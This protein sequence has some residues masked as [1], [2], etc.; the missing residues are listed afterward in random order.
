[1]A[2]KKSTAYD[3]KESELK[4]TH[5][6]VTTY[7]ELAQWLGNELDTAGEAIGPIESQIRYWWTLYEQGRT[8]G[9]NAPWPDAADL[10]SPM[11]SELVDALHARIMQT[12]FTEPVWT[13]EGW[14]P[15]VQKAPFVEEF[16]QRAVE[17]ER[18]QSM[19]DQVFLRSLVEPAGILEVS[20][21]TELRR[22][23]VRKRVKWAVDQMT[24][25]PML[26]AKQQPLPETTEDGAFVDAAP[27]DPHSMEVEYDE[28]QPIRKGPAY[29][30]VPYLDFRTLP[31]HA[32]DRTQIWGYAKRFWRRVPEL[33][34]CAKDGIYD[35]EAVEDLGT[36]N[37]RDNRADEA[38]YQPLTV[39]SQDG[40]TAQKELWSVQFLAD[41]DGKGERWYRATLHKDKRLLLRLHKDDRVTRYFKFVPFPKP[42]STDGYSVV[43]NKLLTIIEEDT[44]VRNMR[45]D[46][47]A[48]AIAS[49]IKKLQNALW[50]EYEQPFGPR[51]VIQVRDMRELE[52]MP[53][54]DVPQ[55]I[56][57]WKQDIRADADRQLGLNDTSLAQESKGDNTLGEVRLR[58]GYA[59]IRMDLVIKR[60]KEPL[61]E[62]WQARHNIYLRQLRSQAEGPMMPQ[63]MLIGL[64]ARGVDTTGIVDGR[65]TVDMLEGQFWAKPKGSVESADLNAQMGYFNQGMVALANLSKVNQ[66]IGMLL[67]S[68]PAAKAI[69]EQ[70]ARVFR[71]QD[72]QAFLGSEA[73]SMITMQQQQQQMMADPRM[74]LMLA[75]AQGAGG[76]G[77][78]PGGPPGGGPG[79]MPSPEA[80]GA[81][82][83]PMP[84]G[85]VQ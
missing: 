40:P 28:L 11:A 12:V 60:M 73:Q 65:I 52:Q 9:S 85:M 8:R 24:G 69:L 3:L 33:E 4:G 5:D 75:M 44:A 56:N 67:S 15:S 58:A 59:E 26:D 70:W 79:G 22:E 64:E 78:P 25:S 51:S 83:G 42:G 81:P 80:G 38:P 21:A 10:T 71:W 32:K 47:A 23:Q 1:M 20:E 30:V 46:K 61:E 18:L 41:L 62:L 54:Q 29:D 6:G 84:G 68:P 16:H 2:R 49:P 36:E 34:K 48:L 31:A 19:L 7:E 45:A 39:A 66:T 37:E 14:G 72:K 76:P 63:S 35:K 17:E 77:G 50:D 53:L 57:V 43:G 55:S 27:E 82:P 13:V 74:K